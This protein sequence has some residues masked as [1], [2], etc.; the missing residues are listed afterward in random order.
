[1]L[2]SRKPSADANDDAVAAA[3]ANFLAAEKAPSGPIAWEQDHRN[4]RFAV[5]VEIDGVTEA[6][7][8]LFDR[9]SL[10]LPERNVTLG[11][12]WNDPAGHGGNFGR[13]DWR[14]LG[15]H[16]NKGLGP[17]AHRFT[18]IKGVHHHTFGE[19]AAPPTGVRRTIREDLPMA[20]PAARSRQIGPPSSLSPTSLRP[21][22]NSL[23]SCKVIRPVTW[24]TTAGWFR[25][26]VIALQPT[27]ARGQLGA[28][29]HAADTTAERR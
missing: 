19:D 20:L 16:T 13:L 25:S 8:V 22:S 10:A 18:L 4:L 9:A 2:R 1:M 28:R 14:P 26:D 17:P 29:H 6:G 24:R 23:V 7:M 3:L 15:D 5:A 21:T 27:S 11:L 12:S